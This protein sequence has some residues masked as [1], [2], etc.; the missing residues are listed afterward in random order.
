MSHWSTGSG[1]LALPLPSAEAQLEQ[2]AESAASP[3]Y[4]LDVP[5]AQ[6]A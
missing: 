4:P 3:G 6:H 5:A 1:S 2:H